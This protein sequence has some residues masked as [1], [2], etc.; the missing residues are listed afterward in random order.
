MGHLALCYSSSLLPWFKRCLKDMYT[1]TTISNYRVFKFEQM[2]K[3]S[4]NFVFSNGKFFYCGKIYLNMKFTILTI[5]K[6][7]V[8]WH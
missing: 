2:I 1:E 7:T 3:L 5:F 4:L 6:Y 8:L